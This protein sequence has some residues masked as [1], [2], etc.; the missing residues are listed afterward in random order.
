MFADTEEMLKKTKP[1]AVLTYTNT[2]DHRQVV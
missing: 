2:F 1:Q